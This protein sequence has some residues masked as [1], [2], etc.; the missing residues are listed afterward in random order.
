MA[1]Q[2]ITYP[3]EP[4]TLDLAER[5]Y[6]SLMANPSFDLNKLSPYIGTS[7]RETT[8]V[9]MFETAVDLAEAFLDRVELNKSQLTADDYKIINNRVKNS[10]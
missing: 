3:I 7:T 10:A 1:K 5:I 2:G 4:R 9:R 6:V 8:C